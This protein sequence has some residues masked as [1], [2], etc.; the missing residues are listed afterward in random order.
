MK[1]AAVNM[2]SQFIKSYKQ[3]MNGMAELLQNER[4]QIK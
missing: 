1:Y 2:V 3:F 4:I